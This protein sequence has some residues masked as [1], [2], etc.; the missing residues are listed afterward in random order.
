MFAG[1]GLA[2]VDFESGRGAY[3]FLKD[4][5]KSI[6]K[7]A[8]SSG[9]VKA[10]KGK[11]M[12]ED[13]VFSKEAETVNRI[14][15]EKGVAGAGDIAAPDGPYRGMA[16]RIFQRNLDESSPDLREKLLDP[17][18]KEDII[19]DILYSPGTETAKARTVLG[20]VKDYPAYVEKQ[21]KAGEKVAPL[22]GFINNMIG[23]RVK[24]IF[25][26]YGIDVVTKSMEQE[27]VATEVAKIT[28]KP[29]DV[30]LTKKY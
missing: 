7:G 28:V 30:I 8:L 13:I 9:V 5:N 27:G 1:L 16:E 2:K 22:S 24:E 23:E 21:K 12:F 11:V 20:L 18:T 15:K 4:Y 10:T 19:A 17:Q 29:Q 14:Y 6:H 3:K 26:P 25:K